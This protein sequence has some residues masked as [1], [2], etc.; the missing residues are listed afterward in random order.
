MADLD[1]LKQ[2]KAAHDGAGDNDE[3]P[4]EEV[5]VAKGR[6]TVH[7]IRANSSIM[8]LKKILGGF[9]PARDSLGAANSI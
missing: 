7:H 9:A 4:F 3:V 5:D 8:H 2:L 1:E 6:Q